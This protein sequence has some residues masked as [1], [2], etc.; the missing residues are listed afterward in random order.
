MKS[1]CV[2]SYESRETFTEYQI[3]EMSS[4]ITNAVEE[5]IVEQCSAVEKGMVELERTKSTEDDVQ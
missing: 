2:C 5:V 4:A 1:N 3:V